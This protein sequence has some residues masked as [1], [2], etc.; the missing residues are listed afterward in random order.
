[1]TSYQYTKAGQVTQ[2]TYPS[3]RQLNINH[4]SI[5]A[6]VVDS[7][8]RGQHELFERGQLQRGGADD[9]LDA[10]W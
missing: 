10:G 1:V 4:D 8:Q 2:L 9:G 3:T 5:R 7:E 6:S